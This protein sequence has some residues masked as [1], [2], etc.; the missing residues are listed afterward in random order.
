MKDETADVTTNAP[1]GLTKLS[2]QKSGYGIR[3]YVPE[4]S[5]SNYAR[6]KLKWRKVG[7]S[8]ST[9]QVIISDHAFRMQRK[10]RYYNVRVRRASEVVLELW[11]GKCLLLF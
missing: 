5:D 1:D 6:N 7:L 3:G 8:R 9:R 10:Q 4:R 2:I 11:A